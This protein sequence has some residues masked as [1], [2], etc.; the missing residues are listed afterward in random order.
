MPID[1][2]RPISAA[3]HINVLNRFSSLCHKSGRTK[4]GQQ[5]HACILFSRE[6][7]HYYTRLTVYWEVVPRL[8]IY[9]VT[10]CV[11]W[12]DKSGLGEGSFFFSRIHDERSTE[13][14]VLRY[15]EAVFYFS[16]R[17]L[18]LYS[19][20]L[21]VSRFALGIHFSLFHSKEI[22]RTVLVCYLTAIWPPLICS[23][24]LRDLHSW[25]F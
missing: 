3:Q 23:K 17:M 18:F 4:N 16:L 12:C 11:N 20:L 19:Q 15:I 6:K 1:H 25:K 7:I 22:S 14:L 9:P 13:E 5:L 21:N 24:L 8:L 10:I 2:H